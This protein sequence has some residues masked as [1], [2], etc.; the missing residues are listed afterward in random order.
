MPKITITY[1]QDEIDEIAETV[2]QMQIEIGSLIKD[3][4][5]FNGRQKLYIDRLNDLH[6]VL[7]NKL[8]INW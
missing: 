7:K 5:K 2:D 6:K 1:T 3:I 8:G 4:D